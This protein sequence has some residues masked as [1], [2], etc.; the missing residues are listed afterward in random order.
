MGEFEETLEA[1]EA[2]K[3]RRKELKRL[4]ENLMKQYELVKAEIAY[5]EKRVKALVKESELCGYLD[6]VNV[7]VKEFP[8]K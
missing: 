5:Y 6:T 8:P 3:K 7:E 2:A 4:M 1:L